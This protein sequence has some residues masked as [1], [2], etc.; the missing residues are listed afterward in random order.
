MAAQTAPEGTVIEMPDGSQRVKRGGQWLPQSGFNTAAPG[1]G[2]FTSDAAA[3]KL[4]ADVQKALGKQRDAARTAAD[5]AADARRFVDLN[6]DVATG[7]WDTWGPIGVVT[8]MMDPKK[9]EMRSIAERLVPANREPGSGDMSNK[10]VDMYRAAELSIEKPGPTNQAMAGVMAAGARRQS[11]YASFLDFYI[12]RR[13]SLLGSEEAWASYAEANPLFEKGK[14][15]TIVRKTTPW[16]QWFGAEAAAQPR[17]QTPAPARPATAPAR[18][19]TGIAGQSTVKPDFGAM[20]P[21]Q[22][23][24]A[25]RFRGTKAP[26]GTQENPSIPVSEA[27]YN[28]LPKGTVWLDQD[29]TPRIKR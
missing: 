28:A 29:G 15:G 18:P 25:G 11:D 9:S 3:P 13:G 27:Q 14:T 20:S 6:E 23:R 4:S 1:S 12:Q 26:S 16:R 17:P 5:A 10:D 19:V 22:R 21:A 7:G 8:S 2:F 24:A